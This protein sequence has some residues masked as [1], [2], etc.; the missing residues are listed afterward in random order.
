MLACSARYEKEDCLSRLTNYTKPY[1]LY[2]SQ[3]E[4]PVKEKD[5]RD[6][7]S[8]CECG[9]LLKSR[10]LAQARVGTKPKINQRK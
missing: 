3:T 9:K 4:H 10:L 5:S 8:F 6:P 1:S 2:K 7:L